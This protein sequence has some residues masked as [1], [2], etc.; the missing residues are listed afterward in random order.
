M[1]TKIKNVILF[2]RLQHLKM[3]NAFPHRIY[4][5]K[6][7]EEDVDV[8]YI[9][10]TN[11]EQIE[12]NAT[13]PDTLQ[14]EILEGMKDVVQEFI[15]KL[16]QV[17]NI[18]LNPHQDNKD[19]DFRA[20]IIPI[21]HR[22]LNETSWE[23]IKCCYNNAEETTLT[24]R[25]KQNLTLLHEF[26]YQTTVSLIDELCEEGIKWRNLCPC[27]ETFENSHELYDHMISHENAAAIFQEEM[28]CSYCKQSFE[29]AFV[30][31]EHLRFSLICQSMVPCMV[32]EKLVRN[33]QAYEHY[34]TEHY[35]D[36]CP[37]CKV[38]CKQIDNTNDF[39]S[40]LVEHI[41]IYLCTDSKASS[42]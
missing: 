12:N 2:C 37:T 35:R 30:R 16:S 15:C 41:Y 18:S 7:D 36:Q 4:V 22:I 31:S 17:D 29:N 34:A 1:K 24:L 33:I 14:M 10:S 6:P 11:N 3:P 26:K 28:T 42:M 20:F 39:R 32:C 23:D 40:H 25:D 19:P 21:I 9:L 38:C 13:T 5:Q 8:D 27:G